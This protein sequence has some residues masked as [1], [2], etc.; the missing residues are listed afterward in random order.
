MALNI[1][2][3]YEAAAEALEFDTEVSEDRLSEVRGYSLE[4]FRIKGGV[5]NRAGI[6]S[7]DYRA[8]F[9]L[10]AECDRC[11]RPIRRQFDCSFKHILLRTA[12]NEDDE[13]IVTSGD[14]LELEDVAVQDAL[15]QLPAKLLCR[16]DCKGLCINCG[17]DL[18][19]GSCG[20]EE[21]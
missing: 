17:A 15:L 5:Y 1:K 9:T 4:D 18:N 8:E 14:V 13:Y 2:P 19:L 7:L 6:V 12:D 11:L 10:N 21:L 3:I 16:D 20:C